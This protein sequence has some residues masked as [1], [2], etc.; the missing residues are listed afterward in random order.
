MAA[1]RGRGRLFHP[2]AQHKEGAAFLAQMRVGRGDQPGMGD[3]GMAQQQVLDLLGGDLFAAPVDLVLD[4]ADDAQIA[5]L[6][7]HHVAGM[8]KS[9]RI[10]G[11]RVMIRAAIIAPEGIGTAC[12]Q[13]AGTAVGDGA[14]V[15]IQHPDFVI[16]A[17]RTALGGKNGLGA[18][19]KPGIVHQPLGH[20]KDL[21]QAAAQQF[22]DA[23]RGRFG[24][25]G[26]ADQHLVQRRQLGAAGGVL[27]NRAQ[28]Q[29]DGGRDQRRHGH[30]F[31]RDQV[32]T[33]L[34]L[35]AGRHDDGAAGM[36]HTQRPGR[37]EREV[38]PR[39]QRAQKPRLRGHGADL[40]AGTDRV[41]VIVMG[42]RDQLGRAGAA[43]RKLE[44]GDLIGR[45]RAGALRQICA[46]LKPMAQ[47]AFGCRFTQK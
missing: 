47:A 17:D 6:P 15:L 1:Q 9:I 45:G 25:A 34:R 42:A 33:G 36:E 18:V 3:I 32:E 13:R 2:L 19:L 39:R 38:M 41:I 11:L 31:A 35:G 46:R 10:K 14:A 21:L 22:G 28:P 16:G 40:G 5:A 7:H 24:K 43:A 12:R 27:L 26:A 37:T 30:T 29:G 23:A 8:V 20:A 4:A 44:E